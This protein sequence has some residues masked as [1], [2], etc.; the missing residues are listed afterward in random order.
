VAMT[1]VSSAKVAVMESSEVGKSA[2]YRR[3]SKGPRTLP[4]GTPA[5]TGV[6]FVSLVLTN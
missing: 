3:Y 1:A 4:W 2:V 5:L 6:R